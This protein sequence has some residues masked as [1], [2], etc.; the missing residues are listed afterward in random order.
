[1]RVGSFGIL[2]LRLN[3][4][5]YLDGSR[6]R[7]DSNRHVGIAADYGCLREG[8]GEGEA[9]RSPRGAAQHGSLIRSHT[10]AIYSPDGRA[11]SAQMVL[12]RAV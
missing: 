1:M 6:L 5:T 2:R 4:T 3:E 12:P 11:C 9:N 7:P 8:E 10:G